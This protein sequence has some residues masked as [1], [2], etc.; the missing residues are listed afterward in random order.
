MS[1]WWRQNFNAGHLVW[2]S[3][4]LARLSVTPLCC[5]RSFLIMANVM[6]ISSEGMLVH[7]EV[8]SEYHK[9]S[10]L[11]YWG[12]FSPLWSLEVHEQDALRF[13]IFLGLHLFSCRWP[14]QCLHMSV[15]LCVCSWCHTRK[16]VPLNKEVSHSHHLILQNCLL[17]L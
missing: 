10:A 2:E 13:S 16:L 5:R 15:S 7:Y 1:H 9:P 3:L 11:H 6:N 17:M 8:V 12:L 14:S 4:F